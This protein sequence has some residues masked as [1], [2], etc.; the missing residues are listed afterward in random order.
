MDLKKSAKNRAWNKLC[1]FGATVSTVLLTSSFAQA[2]ENLW[3]YTSG[4]DTRPKGSWELKLSDI[5]AK[6]KSSG[7]YIRHDIRPTVEYGITDK[8]T[9]GASLIIFK[10]DYELKDE[11]VQP[12]YDTQGGQG[13]K[14]N[15]TTLGGYRL[16][17]K[18]NLLSPYK[19]AIGLSLGANFEQRERY[20]LDGANINQNS[21]IVRAF[22]QKNWLDEGV[23][24]FDHRPPPHRQNPSQ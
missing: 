23:S 3:L 11:N 7:K 16:S 6:G 12:M 5:A 8:L 19:D 18:Y 20:R 17:T 24:L 2:E 10:H 1:S 22:I 4:T 21:Y 14:Y 13:G 15:H 9:V